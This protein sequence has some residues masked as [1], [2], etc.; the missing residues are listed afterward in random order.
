MLFV[1][2][3]SVSVISYAPMRIWL[4]HSSDVP[5]REQL[6]TQIRLG[7]VSGDLSARQKLP[8]IR[9]LA[10][11]FHIHANTVSAAY[12][13][14]HRGGWVDF[15][16]GSGV[17]VRALD[18]ATASNGRNELDQLV[19]DFIRTA[20][21]RGYSLNDIKQN[22]SE[23]L[24]SQRP[25]HLL[26]IEPDVELRRILM[27]EIEAGTGARVSGA[28]L[29]DWH[30]EL[31]H[32]APVAMY[33]HGEA[34]R[35]I[36]PPGVE[37]QLLHSTSIVERLKG[38]SVPPVDCLIA[39]VSRWPGFLQRAHAILTA[40]GINPDRLTLLDA[41]QPG[42]KRGIRSAGIV[43]TDSLIASQLSA[44]AT[45]RVVRLISDASLAEL[46]TYVQQVM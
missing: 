31:A 24:D 9:E 19:A 41:R 45:V 25:D 10:R 32:A 34:V 18:D 35:K 5:L 20:R 8:S 38:E 22:L 26:V 36:L 2:S 6:A 40:A 11:R 43:V 30:D 12:R 27:A 46:R 37:C 3:V 4:S 16:K 33:N 39:V 14:L 7:I 15:K 1:R 17:Y 44:G 29:D 21:Q 23:R 13:E 28:G 42:W